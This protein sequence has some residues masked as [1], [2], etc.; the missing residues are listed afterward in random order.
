MVWPMPML[1]VAL[2]HVGG[3]SVFFSPDFFKGYW[4]FQL[5]EDSQERFSFLTDQGIYTPTRVLMGGSDSMAL[6]PSDCSSDVRAGIVQGITHLAGRFAGVC[7]DPDGIVG[8][9]G[10]RIGCVKING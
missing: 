6:L 7:E 1:E 9:V 10:A 2:D 3:A 5:H 8:N 4:Q